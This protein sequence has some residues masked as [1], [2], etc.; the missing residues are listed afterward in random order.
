MKKIYVS[1]FI[2][3]LVSVVLHARASMALPRPEHP[4]PDFQRP[5][6][7]NLNGEWDFAYDPR[8]MG[9]KEQW[10]S[11]DSLPERIVV[12]YPVESELSGIGNLEPGKVVWYLGRFDLEKP[13]DFSQREGERLLIHFGAVDY[14][15]SVWLNGHKL[16]EH[17]GGYSPFTFEIT[18]Y[19]R[20][21]GNLLAVRVFDSPNRYQARGKQSITG[22][23]FAIWYTPVTG[24]WQTVWLERVGDPYI[25]GYRFA[26]NDDLSGG[27]F[28]VLVKGSLMGVLPEIRVF[29]PGGV[30]EPR[31]DVSWSGLS[32]Q[33]S[34][35][36]TEPWS[37]EYPELYTI[38]L[39]LTGPEGKVID[40]VRSYVGIRTIKARDGKIYLN[41]KEFYQKLLL[42]QGYFPGGIYTPKDDAIM[43]ADAEM[44][45][46]MGFNGLRKHQ[47][48]EDPRF[49][50]WC[51]RVGLVVWEEMPSAGVIT[52]NT[53]PEQY[54]ERFCEEWLDV[55]E[56]DYNHPS[57]IAW[58]VYNESWGVLNMPYGPATGKWARRMI[59][60]TRE[61]D[62]TRLVVDNSGGY[63]FDTD[64][65]DFHHYLPTAERS[66]W[67]YENYK[68]EPGGRRG[69]FW[70][71]GA[72]LRGVPMLPTYLPGIDYQ[73]QPVI[74]SEYG[75]FG[76][77]PTSGDK[78]LLELYRDYTLA[79]KD[80][81][82]IVGYC[83]TQPYDVEQE[84][85]G[86]MTFERE[87]KV[88][89]EEIRKINE[90]VK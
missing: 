24:I 60:E 47:K 62:P 79:V 56:R 5:T 70:L 76:Y 72:A 28:E 30:M 86:L 15:A 90:R 68:P 77:Y 37:P 63:H 78:G 41:G 74:L 67:L 8:D 7:Q 65:W 16:G 54:R 43:K 52:T 71:M 2:T 69:Y 34:S 3:V 80:Y 4:R 45:K 88:A 48:I 17:V 38:E 42:D 87:P 84:Q 58:T 29:S 12:P 59:R 50:Y 26:A 40:R 83:Y 44:Y 22:E 18:D 36:V 75:G 21:S 61:A 81:P 31:E 55:I 20:P 53:V 11:R 25:S 89:P 64:V 46:R 9:V 57:I 32:A 66:R 33:W 35:G 73:G 10:F 23:G 85:N 14:R 49:L 39:S 19:V 1:F 13:L 51:D 6:W 82:Y 27:S